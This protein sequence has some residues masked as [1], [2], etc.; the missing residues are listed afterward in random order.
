MP[1]VVLI[2]HIVLQSRIDVLVL[3][4]CQ[5]MQQSGVCDRCGL[6][7]PG[8]SG[9]DPIDCDSSNDEYEPGLQQ[10]D[11]QLEVDG[12]EEEWDEDDDYD[13]D[14]EEE[15]DEQGQGGLHM[16]LP[17]G[18]LSVHINQKRPSDAKL[19]AAAHN[20]LAKTNAE[21][22]KKNAELV[23]TKTQLVKL[24][25]TLGAF[26]ADA[27]QANIMTAMDGTVSREERIDT[28]EQIVKDK[29]M[30]TFNACKVES[31]ALERDIRA[32]NL[33]LEQVTPSCTH[34]LCPYMR[35]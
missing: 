30:A 2:L 11:G 15:E 28:I 18:G 19:L 31:M 23:K 29:L 33:T 14:E 1:C 9:S 3:A 25:S 17:Q 24:Q 16:A 20:D 27:V 7:P 21:L 4:G 32:R 26:V 8:D 12:Y 13:D 6:P 22:D 35:V 5:D 10:H 34:S